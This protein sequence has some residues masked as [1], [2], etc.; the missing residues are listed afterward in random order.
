M[1]SAGKNHIKRQNRLY[2]CISNETYENLIYNVSKK[3]ILCKLTF[4]TRYTN[5]AKCSIATEKSY[6]EGLDTS[7]RS[8]VNLNATRWIAINRSNPRFIIQLTYQYAIGKDICQGKRHLTVCRYYPNWKQ[9][10]FSAQ[11]QMKC[12][13]KGATQGHLTIFSAETAKDQVPDHEDTLNRRIHPRSFGAYLVVW[14][15]I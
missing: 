7:R 13:K 10:D 14:R 3:F 4:K 12:W 6:P 15:A 5:V 8:G 9:N 11:N 1:L 2:L